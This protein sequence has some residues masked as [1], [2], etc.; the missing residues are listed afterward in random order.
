MVAAAS[1]LAVSM[2]CAFLKETLRGVNIGVSA[3]K[4]QAKVLMLPGTIST[5]SCAMPNLRIGLLGLITITG[6][7]LFC[8]GDN[9]TMF[10]HRWY[11]TIRAAEIQKLNTNECQGTRLCK[12]FYQHR[13]SNPEHNAA[14]RR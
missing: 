5:A 4:V 3:S 10:P 12:E 9:G 11:T 14:T 7:E 1:R 8:H 2:C 6:I 13:G